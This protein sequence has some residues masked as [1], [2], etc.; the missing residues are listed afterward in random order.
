MERGGSRDEAGVVSPVGIL[1]YGGVV[2][3]VGLGVAPLQLGGVLH[4]S[5]ESPRGAC[6]EM[7]RNC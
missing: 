4:R 1:D 7:Q 5:W 3:V 2:V 6:M